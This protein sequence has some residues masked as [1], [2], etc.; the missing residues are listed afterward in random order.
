MT[1]PIAPEMQTSSLG[2]KYV[3][4]F[5]EE[6]KIQADNIDIIPIGSMGPW[7]IYLHLVDFYGKVNI[8][9]STMGGIFYGIDTRIS[10]LQLLDVSPMLWT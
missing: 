10:V 6:Q 4:H 3:L 9:Q 7:Y 2:R 5:C 1:I 8:N